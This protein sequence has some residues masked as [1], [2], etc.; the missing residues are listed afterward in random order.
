MFANV[1]ATVTGAMAASR[2]GV[3]GTLTGTVVTSVATSAGTT[4]YQHYLNRGGAK[5][6]AIP[7]HIPRPRAVHDGQ[8][9]DWDGAGAGPGHVA[10]DAAARHAAA[11]G[12]AAPATGASASP[13]SPGRPADGAGASRYQ[14]TEELAG[15]G[16][17][18]ATS[19]TLIHFPAV[20]GG[21]PAAEGGSPAAEGGSPSADGGSP[22]AEGGSPSAE[23]GFPSADGGFPSAD[24]VFPSV[25]GGLPEGNGAPGSTARG[26]QFRWRETD[27]TRV[28]VAAAAT[29]VL[30]IV[31]ISVIEL[32]AGRP[33]GAIVGGQ[34]A[35]GTSIGSVLGRHPG[36]GQPHSPAGPGS[37]APVQTPAQ[38]ANTAGPAP[39]R[40]QPAAPAPVPTAPVPTAPASGPA[41]GSG[42]RTSSTVLPAPSP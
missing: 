5:V 28:T 16:H 32:A 1:L 35:S 2:F 14:G 33:L 12:G 11:D 40:S 7:A 15:N 19:L 8:A 23:G 24:G 4:V 21:L 22:S 18:T 37:S 20:S 9:H 17:H 6:R 29:L 36:T 26:K 30:A 13:G 25:S 27:W 31:V 34:H 42:G 10:A 41:S 38:P 39:A 3:A